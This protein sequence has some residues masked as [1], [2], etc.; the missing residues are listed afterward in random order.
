[1][2]PRD[3]LVSVLNDMRAPVNADALIDALAAKGVVLS[4]RDPSALELGAAARTAEPPK[5]AE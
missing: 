4:P 2:N 1:V 3:A 5:V